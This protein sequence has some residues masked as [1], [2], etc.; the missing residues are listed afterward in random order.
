MVSDYILMGNGVGIYVVF[1]WGPCNFVKNKEFTT[2][3]INN[4]YVLPI[5]MIMIICND[6][7]LG[8]STDNRSVHQNCPDIVK[9][10]LNLDKNKTAYY[11]DKE[12]NIASYDTEI[13][14][15][16]A[17]YIKLKINTIVSTYQY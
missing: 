2:A 11:V 13:S 16:E 7:Q 1:T 5:D 6:N 10:I 17:E 12:K 15:E 3:L 8:I 14:E 4:N 9:A